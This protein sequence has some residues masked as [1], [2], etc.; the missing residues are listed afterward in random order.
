MSLGKMCFFLVWFI[1]W[2]IW[3][4]E[5]VYEKT[6]Y[7]ERI[8]RC[9]GDPCVV[10]FNPGGNGGEFEWASW[11]VTHRHALQ[12]V[13]I[14]G[15]CYSGCTIA[16]DRIR[17]AGKLCITEQARMGFHQGIY[18]KT[19]KAF[20]PRYSEDIDRMVRKAG[21][22]PEPRNMNYFVY[23]DIKALWPTCELNPPLPR[24]DP[25]KKF[26]AAK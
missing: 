16:A 21:G 11:Q 24:S 26:T 19:K 1:V 20:I 15:E 10:A 18:V 6:N 12:L 4:A 22:Y 5:P 7:V 13:V 14:N 17:S 25:R 9:T 2:S 23:K 8:L 3:L